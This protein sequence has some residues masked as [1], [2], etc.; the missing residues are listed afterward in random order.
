MNLNRCGLDPVLRTATAFITSPFARTFCQCSSG[1]L[2][3]RGRCV[4]DSSP[5]CWAVP[6]WTF[7]IFFE[8]YRM[9]TLLDSSLPGTKVFGASPSDTLSMTSTRSWTS[10]S[11]HSAWVLLS[12]FR[13]L[14]WILSEPSLQVLMSP[15][16]I[17]FFPF[18]VRS[19]LSVSSYS[20]FASSLLASDVV[21]LATPYTMIRWIS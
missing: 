15:H 21:A 18:S 3:P 9:S 12:E 16:R 17:T 6:A 13:C 10:R 11:L 14:P 19:R 2:H 20:S 1:K 5:I 7:P 4:A 8:Q